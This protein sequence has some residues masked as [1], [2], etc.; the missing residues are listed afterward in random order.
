VADQADQVGAVD[1]RIAESGTAAI[2]MRVQAA[3]ADLHDWAGLAL[4]RQCVGAKLP[5]DRGGMRERV[6]EGTGHD[7]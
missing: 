4:G 3:A 7:V 2:A 5:G 6:I 1:R